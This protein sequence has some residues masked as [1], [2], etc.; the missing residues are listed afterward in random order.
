[1]S[2]L[3][4]WWPDPP[5][6]VPADTLANAAAEYVEWHAK[7]EDDWTGYAEGGDTEAA[8]ATLG[9]LVF[10]GKH[11]EARDYVRQQVRS[12]AERFANQILEG[13]S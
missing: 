4:K 12:A 2:A 3:L 6:P 11:D 5:K 9:R 10:E 8:L 13:Q 7:G 1:M